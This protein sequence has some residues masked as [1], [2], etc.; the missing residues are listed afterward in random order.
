MQ[1]RPFVVRSRHVPLAAVLLFVLAAL[2]TTAVRA[3]AVVKLESF[4][5]ST[6][7]PHQAA[8]VSLQFNTTIHVPF[9]QCYLLDA[10][11]K[12]T[13]LATRPGDGQHRLIVDLP[14]L[15]P[16]AHALRYR[17]LAADGHYTDNAFRFRIR[18]EP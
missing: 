18:A 13:L 14:A 2:T 8:S 6:L 7:K 3:H 5:D 12:E 16:G 4:D 10:A 17:V 15:A 11:G 9:S 1:L